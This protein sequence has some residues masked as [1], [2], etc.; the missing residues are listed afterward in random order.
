MAYGD[1]RGRDEVDEGV[2]H[3]V[4][5]RVR[6]RVKARARVRV[7]V[8]VRVRGRGWVLGFDEG[9]ADVTAVA[10]VDG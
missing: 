2:A 10:E 9:V 6:V 5:V 1:V 7:R 3:L 4:R 8:R